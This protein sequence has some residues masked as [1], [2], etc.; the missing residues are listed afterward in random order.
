MEQPKYEDYMLPELHY[1]SDGK[2][3][4]RRTIIMDV[5]K[6]MGLTKEMFEETIP[7]GMPVYINRG[8]WGLTYLKQAG[9]VDTPKRGKFQITKLGLDLLSQK[10]A[11]LRTIDLEKYPKF[12]EFSK[13]SQTKEEPK[14]DKGTSVLTPEEAI[15]EAQSTLKNQV[16]TEL[17]EK[18]RKMSPE[19]F[20]Q[21]VVA[22]LGKMG[23]GD[24][25]DNGGFVVGQSGDGGI[26]GVIKQDKLGLDMIY[27][28]AKRYKEGN[29]VTP[30]DVRDFVG[31]LQGK[32]AKGARKGVF[33]TAS[34]F[35]KEGREYIEN[36]KDGKVILINGHDL[37]EYMYDYDLGV[38]VSKVIP[39]KK[40]DL[41]FFE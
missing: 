22:L 37:V 30:H 8:G 32:E 19:E 27:V 2:V 15:L 25:S 35:T 38:S 29:N 9:L 11:S 7:S 23:Y 18:V 6:S 1:L 10:P 33:I 3:H 40:V 14:D 24:G 12:V 17:L 31:A 28:Q 13:R 26:D 16:C 5:A 21:L 41:D 34:D 4:E 36:I 20:E 39:I